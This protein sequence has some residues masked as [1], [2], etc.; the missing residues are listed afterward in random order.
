MQPIPNGRIGQTQFLL[1]AIA[2]AFTPDKR[3]DEFDLLGSQT[4]KGAIFKTPFDN[5]IAGITVIPG[6]PQVI[7]ADRT[8]IQRWFHY[9]PHGWR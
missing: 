2:P 1:H 5:R 6:D 4:G 8:F 3:F 7:S 9:S